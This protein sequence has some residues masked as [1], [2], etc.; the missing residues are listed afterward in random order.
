MKRIW[1]VVA[2]AAV[3]LAATQ[4]RAD[5]NPGAWQF[6]RDI[7][8]PPAAAGADARFALDADV[9]ANA[10]GPEFLDLRILTDETKEVG[11]VLFTPE[12]AAPALVHPPAVKISR[13]GPR[14][15][16]LLDFGP[17]PY[18]VNRIHLQTAGAQ[19]KAAAVVEASD[20]G[21]TWRPVL[22][23]GAI[24]SFGATMIEK[25]TTLSVPE[26][27]ARLLRV[28]LTPAPGTAAFDLAGVMVF[29]EEKPAPGA[30]PLWITWPVTEA[31]ERQEGG[32]T[33]LVLD[34]GHKG[35]PVRSVTI[36]PPDVAF[37][38][39]VSIETSNDGTQWT[40]AGAGLVF[41]SP[42][43]YTAENL[44]LTFPERYARY[45]RLRTADGGEAPV[46]F[47]N[48]TVSGRMRYVFFPCQPGKK[49]RLFYGNPKAQIPPYDYAN[50]FQGI[51]RQAV[52]AAS[53]GPSLPNPSYVAPKPAEA[54]PPPD[55][56]WVWFMAAGL[57]SA[58]VV[59]LGMWL[60]KRRRSVKVAQKQ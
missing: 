5:F 11:L 43:P 42:A 33:L 4:V 29:S 48:C 32:E 52:I 51:D 24:F 6:V 30:L 7:T 23:A 17:T 20:D 28:T 25:F 38:R 57:G 50:I 22:P 21:T 45:V 54:A 55:R 56:R 34:L 41:R 47:R 19:F 14:V 9:W 40:R 27:T 12:E 46:H 37:Q 3:A 1:L 59:L 2:T 44:T 13:D 10:N 31:K 18:A 15:V 35:L 16:A 39:S 36:D 49:Y 58:G 8:L 53:L 60:M 26:T